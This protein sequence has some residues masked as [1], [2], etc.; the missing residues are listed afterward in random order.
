MS[1]LTAQKGDIHH[2][3]QLVISLHPHEQRK[4]LESALSYLTNRYLASGTTK[5]TESHSK[6]RSSKISGT[7]ALLRHL[8]SNNEGLKEDLVG[9]LAGNSGPAIGTSIAMKR[10]S[11][12]ALAGDEGNL[13]RCVSHGHILTSRQRASR[14][15]W[16]RLWSSLG[17]SCTSSILQYSSRKVQIPTLSS[18]NKADVARNGTNLTV[19]LWLRAPL[20]PD[21]SVYDGEVEYL[22][23]R[24]IKPSCGFVT[25]RSLS[26]YGSRHGHL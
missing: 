14:E 12:A 3:Q 13:L 5:E 21:V 23:E 1:V 19:D 4:F 16:R 25:T 22:H 17:I 7:A 24:N 20:T 6:E 11:L 8:I 26:R 10:A 15:S 18:A 2:L 9:W